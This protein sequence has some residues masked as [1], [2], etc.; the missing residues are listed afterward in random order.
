[1]S[2][3]PASLKKG[4]AESSFMNE[5]SGPGMPVPPMSEPLEP[6]MSLTMWKNQPMVPKA[7]FWEDGRT[8]EIQ[9]ITDIRRAAC[10]AAG[11]TGIRYT[12][13]VDGFEKHLYYG[14]DRRWFV[15]ASA[16]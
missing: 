15:E 6:A 1:M 9:K 10:P 3:S 5:T 14:D 7:I 2:P 16:Q 4:S 13:Y 8:Y 12:I 11:A